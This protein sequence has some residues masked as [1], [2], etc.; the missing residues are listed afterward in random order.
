MKINEIINE[1]RDAS[2]YHGLASADRVK[3]VL[4]NDKLVPYSNVTIAG[5]KP[6]QAISLTRNKHLAYGYVVLE[7]DQAKL[8]QRH[9]MSPVDQNPAKSKVSPDPDRHSKGMFGND[10]GKEEYFQEEIVVGTI[11]PLHKYIKCIK[12]VEPTHGDEELSPKEIFAL[13]DYI[14]S[15]AQKYNVE[16][17]SDWV[18]DLYQELQYEEEYEEDDYLSIDHYNTQLN[19]VTDPQG[20]CYKY[21]YQQIMADP[22]LVLIHATVH[23]PWDHHP[24]THAWVEDGVLVKD[25]QTMEVGLSKYGKKG[26]PKHKFYAAYEPTDASVYSHNDVLKY[27]AQ[28]KHYG[29]W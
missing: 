14:Q 8:A 2:L 9:K 27:V 17:N 4:G 25:W 1:G 6:F 10:K 3:F 15:Y 23:D 24:Y 12:I 11:E 22:S 16:V 5:K 18:E 19:E 21:A 20:L 28:T 13:D 26:W 7:L 29:P